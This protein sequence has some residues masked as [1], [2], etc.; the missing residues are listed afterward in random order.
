[1]TIFN[2]N[3]Q[4]QGF[5]IL[6]AVTIASV[7]LAIA[8][9][10]TKIAFEEI[11]LGTSGVATNNAF[12]AA[13]TGVEYA[14]FLDKEGEF[15]VVPGGINTEH[16]IIYDLS[17]PGGSCAVISVTKDNTD[18]LVTD[19]TIVSKGYNMGDSNCE[20]SNLDRIEREILVNY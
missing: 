8:L 13:D 1:M 12:F 3:K 15:S 4:K 7:V 11:K 19:T 9:G 10:I 14:L 18:P 16:V 20:S 2:N 5:V 6:F 17:G